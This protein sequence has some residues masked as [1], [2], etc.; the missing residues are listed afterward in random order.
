MKDDPV[1]LAIVHERTRVCIHDGAPVDG[2]KAPVGLHVC[3]LSEEAGREAAADLFRDASKLGWRAFRRR[4]LVDVDAEALE[5]AAQL[6]ADADC[7]CHGLEVQ[8]MSVAPLRIPLP[9][10]HKGLVGIQQGQV[11]ALVGG[12]GTAGQRERLVLAVVRDPDGALLLLRGHCGNGQQLW[13]A[14][15]RGRGEQAL[16]EHG[17][18]GGELG[19]ARAERPRQLGVGVERAEREEQLERAD[20]EARGR[21]GQE[22]EARDVVDAERLELQYHGRQVAALDLRDG[23]GRQGGEAGRSVQPVA[24]ARLGAAG[25]AGALGGGGAGH[26]HGGQ[27]VDAGGGIVGAQLDEAAVDDIED[28]VDGDGGFGDVGG[29]DHLAY[30]GGRGF[31]HGQLLR[32]RQAGVQGHR[33]E[34]LRLRTEREGFVGDALHG[35]RDFVGAGEE[36][37]DIAGRLL[38]VDVDD[39]R[40]RASEI[41]FRGLLEVV[42]VDRVHPARYVK[43]GGHVSLRRS[44]AGLVSFSSEEA[45]KVVGLQGGARHDY[46]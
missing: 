20:D 25:A 15:E 33:G 46:A 39:G 37:E 43:D 2:A 30:V 12:E 8:A 5:V 21:G 38:R 40:Y 17:L 32:G 45:Q 41:V 35:G 42:D 28:A 4:A 3:R 36:D 1:R 16:C 31:K 29:E 27:R 13:Q 10:R 14:A 9:A 44:R 23:R 24:L 6:V 22:V 19:H 18:H 34:A 11:I 26:G 7:A